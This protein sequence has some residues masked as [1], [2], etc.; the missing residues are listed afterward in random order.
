LRRS[1][2]PVGAAP[3]VAEPPRERGT[4]RRY[5]PFDLN[6]YASWARE[7]PSLRPE[8]ITQG[9]TDPYIAI[10]IVRQLGRTDLDRLLPAVTLLGRFDRPMLRGEL[11][12]SDEKFESAYYDLSSQEWIDY[13]PDPS[14]NTTFLE[15]DR[16]LRPRLLS[17]YRGD[18]DRS[19][20]LREARERLGPA[21]ARL[22]EERPLTEIGVDLADAAMRLLPPPDAARLWDKVAG[23][24]RAQCDW[25]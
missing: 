6:L 5:N 20:L 8:T 10:R 16:N 15:V 22:A 18:Q 17:Y 19:V 23:K 14:L 1:P 4:E 25:A 3:V 11:A 2:A 12:G 7:D 13:Q 21:L 9:T 24:I